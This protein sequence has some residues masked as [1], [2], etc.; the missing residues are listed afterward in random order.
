MSFLFEDDQARSVSPL[1]PEF[2]PAVI[3]VSHSCLTD[4]THFRDYPTLFLSEDD[5]DQSVPLP[6]SYLPL[7]I[8]FLFQSFKGKVDYSQAQNKFSTFFSPFT[9]LLLEAVLVYTG[10]SSS[11]PSSL[12][13]KVML[14]L[15]SAC[16]SV[17]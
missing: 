16:S 6:V 11:K 5:Q 1:L 17:P 13:T 3:F 15:T 8:A 7:V 2:S 9:L 10:A 4:H 14:S 12:S